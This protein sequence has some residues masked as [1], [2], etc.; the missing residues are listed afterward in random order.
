VPNG[1]MRSLATVIPARN[2]RERLR[3]DERLTRSL[4]RKRGVL[5]G[6]E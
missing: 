4:R 2:K 6:W 5:L 3:A 1:V